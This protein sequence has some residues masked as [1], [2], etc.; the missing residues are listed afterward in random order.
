MENLIKTPVE[1]LSHWAETQGDAVY[2]RQPI[3]G[4]FVDFT[5]GEVQQKVQQIAGALRHLGLVPGDKVALLS[6]NCAEWFITDLA[7]M[8]G[9][10]I[11][12]PIYPTANAEMI[13]YVLE[14]SGAKAIFTGKLDFWADQ[15]AGVGG[16]I[17]RLALPY[18]TMPAQYHWEKLLE[19]GQPLVDAPTP[20]SDQMMTL[21]YTSGSTGKPKGAMQTFGSYGWTCEA[22]VRDLKTNTTDRLLSYLPLAHI[23]ERVAIQGSS[24]Y[25]GSSV[26]FVES[27]D[28]FVADVQRCRPTVFFSVPRLWTLFQLNIV[29]KIGQ[30]K[31]DLLLKIPLVSGLVKRKIQKGLGLEHCR[32]LGSGS[33]PIPPSQLEWYN[34]IGMNISEAWGMTENCAYSIINFPFN[35]SKIGSV[36]RPVEGCQVRR[37]DEGE[38]M[39][40]SPGL[41]TGYYKQEEA[42]A[43]CFDADGFFHTGDLCEIDEDGYISITGRVKDNFKTSKGKYV[44]PVPI[45]RK[46]AQDPHIE[47]L[48]VIGSGLPHPITLVQLSEGSALQA[49]EEVRASLKATLD[50]VNPHLESHEVVDAIVVVT[51]P[52]TIEN[53]A[54][55]PTL[56]IK[57]HVLE[58]QFS[59]KVD[60]IRGAKVCWEDEI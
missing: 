6:K 15:E 47:L 42:T 20:S 39:V 18:D 7:L 21:I 51:E 45:E 17:L 16:E 25:S 12:V 49:R 40:K 4:Q 53:D 31:L 58:K 56:K 14:H 9:G 24:F 48:C 1:M 59:A 38:L 44:A 19:L 52:W 50:G 57:R 26:A 22:V 55:T 41:M 32:L 28:S 3:N 10:Y 43:A 37:T 2:L 11:S 34:K 13:R 29:N 54:L 30:S 46:I 35:A 5:W 33:A 27:L 23:T 60:G 8:H 36:G